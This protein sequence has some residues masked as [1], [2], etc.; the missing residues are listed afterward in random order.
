VTIN[1]DRSFSSGPLDNYV[2]NIHRSCSTTET[3]SSRPKRLRK[4][5]KFF[6]DESET[7]VK[8]RK[9][10]KKLLVPPSTNVVFTDAEIERQFGERLLPE[11]KCEVGDHNAS[12]KPTSRVI[13]E[14]ESLPQT[15]ME[16]ARA[17]LLQALERKH[18]PSHGQ[19]YMFLF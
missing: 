9:P 14:I 13:I 8:T 5:K 6:I 16:R 11:M 12:T 3:S 15:P 10:R 1:T 4:Q 18:R 17:K 7:P 19:R 2:Q